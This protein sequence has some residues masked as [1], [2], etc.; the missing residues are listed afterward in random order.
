MDAV[1]HVAWLLKPTTTDE[2][3]DNGLEEGISSAFGNFIRKPKPFGTSS[4]PATMEYDDADDGDDA[5][6]DSEEEGDTEKILVE[7]GPYETRE[8][9]KGTLLFIDEDDEEESTHAGVG[10]RN[11]DDATARTIM[12]DDAA[13]GY[14]RC[15]TGELEQVKLPLLDYLCAFN[16]CSLKELQVLFHSVQARHRMVAHLQQKCRLRTA[17]LKPPERNLWLHCHDL[18]AQNANR[19][20]ACSGYLELTVRQYY[21][22][23]HGLKLRHPY[24]PCLIEFGGG[25]HASYYPLEVVHVITER[26]RRV[27]S[28]GVVVGEEGMQTTPSSDNS[29]PTETGELTAAVIPSTLPV[30]KPHKQATSRCCCCCCCATAAP[31]YRW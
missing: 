16:G 14:A 22:A 20:F 23:K 26:P 2:I 13:G 3:K 15:C 18:S 6:E 31:M 4:Q 17:H 21:F 7:K 30:M 1:S 24:L 11:T 8:E 25:V 29:H 28:S 27:D 19:T 10:D 5:D 12:T 9:A